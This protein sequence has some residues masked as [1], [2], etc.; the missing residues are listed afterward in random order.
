MGPRRQ[1]A[2][3]S[4]HRRIARDRSPHTQDAALSPR[5]ARRPRRRRRQLPSG[6]RR[7]ARV[8]DCFVNLGWYYLMVYI[9]EVV[10]FRRFKLWILIRRRVFNFS[11]Q[12]ARNRMY[13]TALSFSCALRADIFD[14]S[15]RTVE[16]IFLL[17]SC[18]Y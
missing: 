13:V 10:Q 6:R 16:N 7:R 9:M 14:Y 8:R 5:L 1:G 17:E 15:N 12:A 4:R 3:G 18:Y 2:V 11:C